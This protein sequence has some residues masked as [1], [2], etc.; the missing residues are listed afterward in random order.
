MPHFYADPVFADAASA[1]NRNLVHHRAHALSHAS[2]FIYL[3]VLIFATA[4]LYFLRLSAPQI[5]GQVT[6]SAGQI[7]TLTNEQRVAQGLSA[8]TYNSFL[9]QGAGAKAADMFANDY[10]AHNSPSGRTPWS[11][12]TEAGYKYIFA[13]ENLARDFNDPQSAVGAWMG[14]PSHRSNILDK[15]FR[16][17]G[18]AVSSGKLTGREGILV[19]QM[20]GTS[21]QVPV[22]TAESEAP[23]AA[24][25]TPPAPEATP[26]LEATPQGETLISQPEGGVAVLAGRQFSIAKGISLA[27]VGFIFLLFL[28]EVLVTAKRAHVSL[29]PGVIA[30]LAI[31]GFI[32]FAVW[33]AVGGAIL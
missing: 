32:L 16:E 2:L 31:L 12:I 13:G 26:A 24:A 7:I 4:A 3:Q 25:K 22:R 5:L 8:L 15:N 17:I 30:H 18:V 14:S 1:L 33:Y 27:L 29:K 21:V 9:A 28:L 23:V 11:F 10:W 19:V 6:F 20:F